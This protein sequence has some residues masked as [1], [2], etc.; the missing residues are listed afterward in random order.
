MRLWASVLLAFRAS[1][2]L[3]KYLCFRA[4]ALIPSRW[5]ALVK[6][7]INAS[8]VSPCLLHTF[9]IVLGPL[10]PLISF[11]HRG[12]VFLRPCPSCFIF[13][14]FWASVGRSVVAL[15]RLQVSGLSG[16]LAP[17]Q[18]WSM[19]NPGQRWYM[20]FPHWSPFELSSVRAC[21]RLGAVDRFG[22]QI[23]AP[24]G[25]FWVFF[26]SLWASVARF[27]FVSRT[28]PGLVSSGGFV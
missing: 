27:C 16:P 6:R 25:L 4:A 3:M 9:V 26:A 7:I 8:T 10:F 28:V 22:V 20:M 13:G 11:Y 15:D 5:Q 19:Q 1:A 18:N 24:C 17:G 14:A 23:C 2:L 21:T 12:R